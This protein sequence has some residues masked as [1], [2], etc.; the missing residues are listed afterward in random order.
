VFWGVVLT[1]GKGEE[2]ARFEHRDLHM[3]NICVASRDGS[4]VAGIEN[5][6]EQDPDYTR[7]LGFTGVETTIIDYTLSRAQMQRPSNTETNTATDSDSEAEDVA[8]LDLEKDPALFKGDATVEYQYEMYRH[9][10]GAM[11]LDDPL[12]DVD[13]RWDEA[14][15]SART[16]RGYHPQTNLVWLHF[17][18]HKLLEQIK[19][20]TQAPTFGPTATQKSVGKGE[21]R[22]QRKIELGE[23]LGK[24]RDLLEPEQIPQS[25]LKSAADLVALALS[26]G[27]LDL[28]DVLGPGCGK[29]SKAKGASGRRKGRT[30]TKTDQS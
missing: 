30:G 17:V 15:A 19:I 28:D 16:W 12:A 29:K 8:F 22:S 7:K 5:L 26:E 24:V 6:D 20:P 10:R 13:A 11:Y 27:W 23:I 14:L 21:A 1:L 2:G 18:L 3:G 4:G 9:M 25:G